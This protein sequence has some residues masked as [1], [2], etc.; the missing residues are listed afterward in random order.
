MIEVTDLT[1]S[2]GPLAVLKGMTFRVVR[3]AFVVVLGP[4]GAGKSTLLRCLN[5]LVRPNGGSV[6]VDGIVLDRRHLA[7]VRKRVGF[8]FQGVNVH[9]NQTV[10]Q[11]VLVGRLA[12]KA[13]WGVLFSKEDHRIAL[14]AIDRVGLG[15]KAAVR[16]SSLSGGQRQR[17]G[18]ARALAHDPAVLLADEPVS[19]LD[20]VTGREILELLRAINRERGTTVVCNLHDVGLATRVADRLLGLRAGEIVFDGPPDQLTTENLA[21]LYGEC[22]PDP[23]AAEVTR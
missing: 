7:T 14:A 16:A 13:P 22:L 9:G 11:N 12:E 5:G 2:F 19:S 1:K 17:V 8:I 10:L 20:P 6:I 18:I 23:F 21:R 3:G 15:E 4:S